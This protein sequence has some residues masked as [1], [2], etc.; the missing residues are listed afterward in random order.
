MNHNSRIV[1][2]MTCKEIFTEINKRQT[3]ALML[4]NEMSQYFSF[5][6]LQGFKRMHCY[7]FKNESM[8]HLKTCL[9]YIDYRNELIPNDRLDAI[10]LIPSDWFRVDRL[11][12]SSVAKKNGTIK[13]MTE[14]H[15]WEKETKEV[16]SKY[17]AMLIDIDCIDCANFVNELVI[18][19]TC[20][21]KKLERLVDK[22][23]GVDFDMVYVTEIQSD[24]HEKYKK[25]MKEV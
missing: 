4:H 14:Y 11:S 12:V 25:L 1:E 15:E 21:L 13:A 17:Y 7:Q 10:N 22:L 8:E 9:W 16:Y 3:L 6:G 19:V 24:L 20:E 18:D 5:L 2:G 23:K